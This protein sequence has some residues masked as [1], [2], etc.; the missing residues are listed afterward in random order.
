MGVPAI[1][2]LDSEGGSAEM[3]S[4]QDPADEEFLE[5]LRDFLGTPP[6]GFDDLTW[7][8]VRDQVRRSPQPRDDERAGGDSAG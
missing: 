3:D 5:R 6:D 4:I 8:A 7:T 1:S 2:R